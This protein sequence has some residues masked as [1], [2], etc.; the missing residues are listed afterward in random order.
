[1]ECMKLLSVCVQDSVSVMSL[2]RM[3]CYVGGKSMNVWDLFVYTLLELFERCYFVTFYIV[4]KKKHKRFLLEVDDSHGM[5]VQS[6]YDFGAECM[7]DRNS[8]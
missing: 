3:P 8:S 7:R 1:V 2:V 5:P 6:V 4:Q